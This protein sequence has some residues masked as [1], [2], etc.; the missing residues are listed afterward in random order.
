MN[1]LKINLV[2]LLA[3]VSFASC[4][5]E[6]KNDAEMQMPEE[7][8]QEEKAVTAMVDTKFNDGI[9][10]KAWENYLSLKDAL[11]LTDAA[12]ASEAASNLAGTFEGDHADLKDM[13]MEISNSEDVEKQ[14]ELF[15]TLTAGLGEVFKQGLENGTIY[16]QYCPMAF[17]NEGGYWYSDVEQIKNP[18]F[19][20]KM[21]KCGKVTETISK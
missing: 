19:G 10:G 11:V 6:K 9:T 2:M 18:Y 4:K 7:V 5:E 15:S 1:T 8:K 13:A 16:Q 3:I 20:D 21:L 17:N 12:K 14:R